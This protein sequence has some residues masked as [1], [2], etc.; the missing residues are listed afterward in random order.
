[1]GSGAWWMDMAG[2]DRKAI[3]TGNT[4]LH[5]GKRERWSSKRQRTLENS[6]F[7]CIPLCPLW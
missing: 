7:L 3:T 4:E 1:V 6:Y 2:I 5:R